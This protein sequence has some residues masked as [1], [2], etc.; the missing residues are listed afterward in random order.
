MERLEI[1]T[2]STMS[3]LNEMIL[4]KPCQEK[5]IEAAF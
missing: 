2:L 3:A 4:I 5:F 1:K